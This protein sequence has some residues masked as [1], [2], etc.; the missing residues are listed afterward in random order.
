MTSRLETGKPLTFFTVYAFGRLECAGHS[1]LL[2]CRP[3]GIFERCLDSNPEGCRSKQVRYQLSQS[4]FYSKSFLR[5]FYL[6]LTFNA[7]FQ[8]KI[9]GKCCSFP[10]NNNQCTV[11]SSI[12]FICNHNKRWTVGLSWH[13]LK[14]YDIFTF[15]LII[16][17]R[18]KFQKNIRVSLL[19]GRSGTSW[20]QVKITFLFEKYTPLNESPAKLDRTECINIERTYVTRRATSQIIIL[21]T[22]FNA[23]AQ[24]ALI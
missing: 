10:D 13:Q 24:N 8:T 14:L 17:K 21:K 3:F 6:T 23:N 20:I 2:L 5:I 4:S 9:Y 11:Y 18:I 22:P 1:F 12:F 16:Q 15:Y 7:G 19:P